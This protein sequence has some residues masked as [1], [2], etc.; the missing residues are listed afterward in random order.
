MYIK[1]IFK[2]D[3]I[4]KKEII[5]CNYSLTIYFNKNEYGNVLIPGYID[6]PCDYMVVVS[7]WT[8]NMIETITLEEFN[9]IKELL[10]LKKYEF[11]KDIIKEKKDKLGRNIIYSK[12]RILTTM[13]NRYCKK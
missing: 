9:M 6:T 3:H 8:N 7:N 11:D 5:I 2:E 13:Y 12:Y 10:M 4:Y 1:K